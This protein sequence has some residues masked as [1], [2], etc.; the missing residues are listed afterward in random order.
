MVV[1]SDTTTITNLIHIGYLDLLEKLFSEIIIP[2]EVYQELIILPNQKIQINQ[3]KWIKIAEIQNIELFNELVEHLDKGEAEAIVLA[4]ERKADLLII[5]ELAGRRIA[6]AKK[7]RIIGLLG[8]LIKSKNSG[9]IESLK[10]ILDQL[11]V[12]FGFRINPKL[13]QQVL[14]SVGETL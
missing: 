9:L 13:Y 1:I 6:K 11:I 4:I 8:I 3:E 10:S 12:E 2:N 14:K 5:D 7:I